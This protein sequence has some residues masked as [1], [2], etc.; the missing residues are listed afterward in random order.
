M[1]YA[2]KPATGS[3]NVYFGI[4][5]NE[6]S[7]AETFTVK[8]VIYRWDRQNTDNSGGRWSEDIT[9]TS[10][11]GTDSWSGL[12][13]VAGSGYR[14]IDTFSTRTYTKTH[15]TQTITYHLYTDASF[16][17]YYN[18]WTTLGAQTWTFTMSVPAK[19]SYKV[20]YNANSGTGAPS[21]QTKWHNESL[22]LSS[23]KPTRTG[24]SFVKWNTKS[25]GSGTNYS[26]GAS[27]TGN[28][29][30]TLYAQWTPSTYTVS[31]NANGGSGAPSAQTKTAGKALTLT[32]SKPTR[33]GYNFSKWNTKSDGTGTSYS[34][35]GSYATDANVTLYAQWT[36]ITYT[37][38]YDANGGSGAP[39]SQT[40]TY[41]TTLTLS[42]TKPTRTGY[43]FSKWNTASNGSGTNYS[44][45][46]SYTA[47]A[48]AKLY[49]QWTANTWY[50]KY[51]GN[52][53]TSGSMSNS[54][55]TYNTAKNLTANAFSRAHTVTYN[56][57]YSGSS[58]ATDTA[59]YSF[60]K[61]NTAS[62]GSGTDYANQASVKNLTSTA[63]GTVNLYARW[64]SASVTLRTPTR[65]GHT[66]GGWYK[67]SSCTNK[68]GNAGASYTPTANITLY[69]K[70]TANT[71][72][73]SYNANGGSGA[74]DSQKKTYGT[75]LTLSTAKPT[76]SGWK[77]L[78]WATSSTA[79]SAAYQPGGS[80]TANSSTTLYAVWEATPSISSLTAIRC[81]SSGTVQDDGT[82]AKVTAVWSC[83]QSATAKLFKGTTE[84]TSGKSGTWSGTSGT[85]TAIVSGIDLAS[86]YAF[87]FQVTNGSQTTTRSAVVTRAFFTMDFKSGGEG[88]GILSAAPSRGLAVGGAT[89][90]AS[91]VK[92]GGDVRIQSSN[93][94]RD[95]ALPTANQY[96]ESKMKLYDV[97]GYSIGYVDA[98]RMTD[99]R[100]GIRL[101]TNNGEDV[102]NHLTVYVD[103]SGN[104]SYA[105]A[106][107]QAFR[108]AVNAVACSNTADMNP[109]L[110]A[111]SSAG[112]HWALRADVTNS[113][114]T[115]YN[116]H[117]TGIFVMDDGIALYDWDDGTGATQWKLGAKT[118][119]TTTASSI[120]TAASGI[121]VSSAS[122]SAC[123]KVAMLSVTC[124]GFSASTGSQSI[125]TVVSGKRP[126]QSAYGDFG[127][128]NAT[129]ASLGAGGAIS[130]YWNNAPS[131]SSS[132]TF[133]FMY[134]LP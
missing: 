41:G 102:Y 131:S 127:T 48:A 100:V 87:K 24:Y 19:A 39:A 69:A 12:S 13:Y 68:V 94:D 80:Y 28:A 106:S 95:G 109:C 115:A 92:T 56:H 10:G 129:Y 31:Y 14:T 34:S 43:A 21:A 16:G 84:V 99:G 37:V 122:Y 53:S 15:S 57:N 113:A 130:V 70:W 47:N 1:T 126:A 54:T 58:N 82:Y 123:G 50:V 7:Y 9:K 36:K 51:N 63:G 108:E 119:T 134:L 117:E 46:G 124:T 133:R 67:E 59:T 97:D 55:H 6:A 125:G 64:T 74:P 25:D 44:S 118:T 35:G 4:E 116:G 121:T 120:I 45:G 91:T 33:T 60:S 114:N 107:A 111:L 81:D 5:W 49:A 65:T 8:P 101:M 18:G 30:I 83:S 103:Q 132:Y 88:V 38:S 62:N 61:W 40:K 112:Q 93:I 128:S 26:S 105:V 110:T 104:R 72:T 27:Y 79:T 75:A 2:E 78:G 77:F 66:F 29:A 73:V 17:T 76:R 96:T 20:T 90:F 98:C 11:S 22:T 42:S 52:G 89:E 3:T 85:A 71:Y 32:T 86:Q 23:T